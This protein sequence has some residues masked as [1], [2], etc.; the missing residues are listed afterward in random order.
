LLIGTI[1]GVGAF[2][3]QPSHE[4][5]APSQDLTTS[6]QPIKQEPPSSN[7][8]A[9]AQSEAVPQPRE[10][11]ERV[12][13][14]PSIDP[15]LKRSIETLERKLSNLG[16][17]IDQLKA[18]QMELFRDH[19][20]LNDL[21]AAQIQAARDNAGLAEQ[22]KVSQEQLADLSAQLR[23]SQSLEKA[24]R[25]LSLAH[26]PKPSG[27]PAPAVVNSTRKQTELTTPQQPKPQ[28][29]ARPGLR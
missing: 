19:A 22:F 15:E 24:T 3:W 12:D 29:Q 13:P 25:P 14:G 10:A 23:A 11:A 20:A 6:I 9:V 4:Q 17:D 5:Q 7:P 27:S 26:R 28:T 8:S 16:N 1:V 18:V 21:R 2:V